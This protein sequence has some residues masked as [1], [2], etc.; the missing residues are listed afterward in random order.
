FPVHNLGLDDDGRLFLYDHG[1]SCFY[2]HR[3]AAGIV[4]GVD[5]LRSVEA[6][7]DAMFDMDHKG[8]KYW[9]LLTDL[10][11][12]DYWLERIQQIPDF[13][14]DAFVGQIPPVFN[15]PAP[16]ERQALAEFLKKRRHYLRGH[17]LADKKHFPKLGGKA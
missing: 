3:E 1:N 4:A 14:F 11:L 12:V 7:L 5:R 13:M 2:R 10:K 6:S 15:S 16:E 8:N 17:I 9:E